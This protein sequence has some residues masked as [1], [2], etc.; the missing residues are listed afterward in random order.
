VRS[1]T[2]NAGIASRRF[3][4]RD[5]EMAKRE[6]HWRLIMNTAIMSR[7]AMKG[8]AI[9]AAL[10]ATAIADARTPRYAM[11][12][13]SADSQGPSVVFANAPGGDYIQCDPR[14]PSSPVRC[15]P[16]SW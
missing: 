11:L 6:N 2:R 12:Y 9:A 15:K 8:A 5:A 3:K 1:R 4:Q 14:N 16:D 10:V 13:D 7:S